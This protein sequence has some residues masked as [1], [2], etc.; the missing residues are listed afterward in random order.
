MTLLIAFIL[1]NANG[2]PWWAY[3]LTFIIW[4]CHM[5]Y[6]PSADDVANRTIKKA[7]A[8]KARARL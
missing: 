8:L 1:L 6:H 7:Q 2:Y 5:A 3:V 4:L